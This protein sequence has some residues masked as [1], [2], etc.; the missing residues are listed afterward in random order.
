M[1]KSNVQQKDELK[2]ELK[3]EFTVEFKEKVELK[4]EYSKKDDLKD[5]IHKRP[6][7]RQTQTT[8]TSTY[9]QNHDTNSSNSRPF[10]EKNDFLSKFSIRGFGIVDFLPYICNTKDIRQA[11]S[12][13]HSRH[14]STQTIECFSEYEIFIKQRASSK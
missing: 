6:Q 9:T 10:L 7:H 11:H 3:V 1:Q 4:G 2:D 5:D 12:F 13:T 8:S 14:P